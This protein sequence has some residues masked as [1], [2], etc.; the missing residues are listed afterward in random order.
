MSIMQAVLD[1]GGNALLAGLL[2][3]LQEVGHAHAHQPDLDRQLC[4]QQAKGNRL[5]LCCS[6]DVLRQAVG[7]GPDF[8]GC[9]L[10]LE[11]EGFAF[12]ALPC[13]VSCQML[14]N[15]STLQ[16]NR[17][18]QHRITVLAAQSLDNSRFSKPSGSHCW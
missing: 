12:Q 13:H 11:S 3:D 4:L 16:T 14:C 1:E 10:E 8:K 17:T 15:L 5:N 18:D 9:G 2:P 7:P 6:A